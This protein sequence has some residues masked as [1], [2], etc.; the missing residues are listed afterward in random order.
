VEHHLKTKTTWFY[1]FE[2]N[3]TGIGECGLFKV[4]VLMIDQ[5]MNE[6]SMDMQTY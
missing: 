1:Y 5:I 2:N 6:T 3:K 4:P